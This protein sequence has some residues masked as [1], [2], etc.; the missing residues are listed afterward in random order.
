MWVNLKKTFH[1]YI[2]SIEASIWEKINGNSQTLKYS[3]LSVLINFETMTLSND[4]KKLRRPKVKEEKDVILIY[5]P[6]IGLLMTFTLLCLLF[7]LVLLFE[8]ADDN[9]WG[10]FVCSSLT[11]FCLYN[12]L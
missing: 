2:A 7:V 3:S 8:G 5:D 6:P 11:V 1:T 10:I 9:A 4:F 12:T